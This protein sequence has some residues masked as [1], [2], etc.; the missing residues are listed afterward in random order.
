MLCNLLK[1]NWYFG[2]IC[3]THL[4]SR[5]VNQARNQHKDGSKQ[6]DMFLRNV[7]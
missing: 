3:H 7:S 6:C 2:G 4:Q 1:V 5:K